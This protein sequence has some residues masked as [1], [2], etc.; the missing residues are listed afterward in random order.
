MKHILSHL[1][2]EDKLPLEQLETDP[3]VVISGIEE[4]KHMEDNLMNPQQ[5]HG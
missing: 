3:K 1:G 5:L 4:L 2:Y